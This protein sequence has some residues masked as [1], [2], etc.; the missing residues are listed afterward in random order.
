MSD[1]WDR[2]VHAIENVTAA[3]SALS[4]ASA[5]TERERA[6]LHADIDAKYDAAVAK[7]SNFRSANN[8]I[9]TEARELAIST[10]VSPQ[11]RPIDVPRDVESALHDARRALQVA[12]DESALLAGYAR[13]ER[14]AMTRRADVPP[15]Q[16]PPVPP[17]PKTVESRAQ[18]AKAKPNFALI[19]AAVAVLIMVAAALILFL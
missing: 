15:P 6:R 13:S 1:R 12:R 19:I 11:I 8:A 2:Y 14:R 9:S 16:S 17:V 10:G 18:P 4:R 7:I 5:E 3:N